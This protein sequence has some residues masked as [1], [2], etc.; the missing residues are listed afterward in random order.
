[1][2]ECHPIDPRED[3]TQRPRRWV[4]K[5]AP[6]L[7]VAAVA[8]VILWFGHRPEEGPFEGNRAPQFSVMDLSGE[9]VAS[10]QFSGKPLFINFWATWCEPCRYE[11]PEIQALYDEA[12]GAFE[13]IAVSDEPLPTVR[14]YLDAFGYTFPVFLDVDRSMNQDFLIRALPTSVFVDSKGIIRAVHLGQLTRE[15]ME[16]YLARIV[17]EMAKR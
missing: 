4:H 9:L 2:S 6:L 15:Q 8:A 3:E 5:A 17:P 13:V 11:M 14:R 1:M 12:G 10:S 7:L 16:Q